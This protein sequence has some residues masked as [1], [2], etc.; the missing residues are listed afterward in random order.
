MAGPGVH[1][2]DRTPAGSS[3]KASEEG[4]KAGGKLDSLWLPCSVPLGPAQHQPQE[5]LWQRAG[6]SSV[7]LLG[8]SVICPPLLT[9][10]EL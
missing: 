7:E 8:K 5:V 4:A 6:T 9:H 3:G 1:Q 2:A 10:P